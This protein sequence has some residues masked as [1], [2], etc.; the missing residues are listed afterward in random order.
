MP[1]WTGYRRRFW[2]KGK[3]SWRK[4]SPSRLLKNAHLPAGRDLATCVSLIPR[5]CDV[6][7][8]TPHSSGFRRLPQ[9]GISQ[10]QLADLDIFPQPATKVFF[11]NLP[12]MMTDE[13]RAVLAGAKAAPGS[14]SVWSGS[15][16]RKIKNVLPKGQRTA[17]G[18]LSVK[19]KMPLQAVKSGWCC[20]GADR[21]TTEKA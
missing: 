20:L 17:R 2:R 15:L 6:L 1:T 13:T 18:P 8:S 3:K 16:G 12:E 9:S 21:L 5:R 11:S 14:P 10:A 4:V 7:A 19:K